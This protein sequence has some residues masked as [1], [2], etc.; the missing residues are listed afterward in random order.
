MKGKTPSLA[1]GY[2]ASKTFKFLDLVCIKG[3]PEAKAFVIRR[4]RSAFGLTYQLQWLDGSP[5]TIMHGSNLKKVLA[6]RVGD[7]NA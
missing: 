1:V 5:D 4:N 3:R 2:R 6:L 7:V